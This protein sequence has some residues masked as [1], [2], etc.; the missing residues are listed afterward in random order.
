MMSR[1]VCAPGPVALTSA[2][3][4]IGEGEVVRP[5][6]A[7]G[8]YLPGAADRVPVLAERAG[9]TRRHAVLGRAGRRRLAA[10]E[11]GLHDP[12]TDEDVE[13]RERV[14]SVPGHDDHSTLT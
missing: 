14:H 11:P 10:G 3:P 8:A 1:T 13:A 4:V 12:L 2:D 5:L 7:A 6:A 9:E